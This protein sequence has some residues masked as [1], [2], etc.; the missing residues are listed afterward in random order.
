MFNWLKRWLFTEDVRGY[1]DQGSINPA[2]GLPMAGSV[3]VEGN[4]YGTDSSSQ[5]QEPST[6]ED[7][8]SQSITEESSYPTTLNEIQSG[9]P[10]YRELETPSINPAT[11]LPMTGM[12]DVEGNPYGTDMST[13]YDDTG[14]GFSSTGISTLPDDDP[15][16]RFSDGCSG[17]S[18]SW[19][20]G[21]C[22]PFDD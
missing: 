5:L 18:D 9:D 13:G 14:G 20:I 7:I 6:F 22:G 8:S 19:D 15:I 3:D 12:I 17:F 16:G 21:G 10:Q 11:G 1:F 2:T 4:P